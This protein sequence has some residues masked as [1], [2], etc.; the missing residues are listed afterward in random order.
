MLHLWKRSATNSTKF[1]QP[2][3]AQLIRH[4]SRIQ[5]SNTCKIE[6]FRRQI[7]GAFRYI[8]TKYSSGITLAP[9]ITIATT[10]IANPS[11]LSPSSPQR[12]TR[13]NNISHTIH[14]LQLKHRD[15]KRQKLLRE[16]NINR[17]KKQHQPVISS[18]NSCDLTHNLPST[19]DKVYIKT[20]VF[21]STNRFS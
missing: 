6:I 15:E 18:Y 12:N 3:K 17:Q 1:T 11:S 20:I 21:R 19:N 5:A 9:P 2:F 4:N 14:R 16:K 7:F 13:L 8:L 10:I